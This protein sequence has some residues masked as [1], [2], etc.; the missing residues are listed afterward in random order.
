MDTQKALAHT[1]QTSLVPIAEG[2]WIYRVP[3]Q[4]YQMF[5]DMIP[6]RT[7]Y[8]YNIALQNDTKGRILRELKSFISDKFPGYVIMNIADFSKDE[9]H[10]IHPNL[11]WGMYVQLAEGVYDGTIGIEDSLKQIGYDKSISN[12]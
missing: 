6:N 4:V 8:E 12:R 7:D 3:N 2:L 10:Q 5:F 11:E 1:Q 9:A